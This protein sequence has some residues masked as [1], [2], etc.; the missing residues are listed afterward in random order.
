MKLV[1][2]VS[3][4]FISFFLLEELV[5]KLSRRW[6]VFSKLVPLP[7]EY[8]DPTIKKVKRNKTFF[9]VNVSDY[10]QWVVFA[11]IID[12]SWKYASDYLVDNGTVLD[13]GSN[14]GAFSLKLARQ[15]IIKDYKGF[16]IH[17]FDPNPEIAKVFRQNLNL[18]KPLKDYVHFHQTGLGSE[19]KEISFTFDRNNSGAGRISENGAHNINLTTVDE[20][21]TKNHLKDIS[22][23]KIDV[24]GYEPEVL[25]GA[26]KTIKKYKPALY[27]EITDQWFRKF[28]S[29]SEA[30]TEYLQ[31]KMNYTLYIDLE[32]G[33]LTPYSN[34]L[35]KSLF[36][37]NLLAKPN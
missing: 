16:E 26:V 6:K 17:A 3:H 25:K 36:Q 5:I 10:M 24:E 8:S 9:R 4:K 21:I 32:N 15:G 27:I 33:H 35:S 12:N 2:K 1:T 28:D 23:I 7:L 20:F 29:S 13:I 14:C 31:K 30:V 18:N 34:E 11:D 19:K 37:F 22:F